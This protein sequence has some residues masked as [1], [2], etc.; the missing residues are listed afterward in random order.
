VE[1]PLALT[2]DARLPLRGYQLRLRGIPVADGIIPDGR[3]LVDVAPARLPAGV[4][5][6]PT[7]HPATGMP[8]RRS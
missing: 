4:D 5:G 1:P 3:L 6:Q 8:R 2:I 7:D